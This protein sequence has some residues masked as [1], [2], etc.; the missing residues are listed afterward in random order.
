MERLEEEVQE[1][2]RAI[3]ATSCHFDKRPSQ[4]F[5]SFHRALLKF[6]FDAVDVRI[7]YETQ[8]IYI[9]NPKPLT[10]DPV[11]LFDMKEALA[12]K[13]SY[14][15]LEETLAGCLQNGHLQFSFYK[16]LIKEYGY[17]CSNGEDIMS[18]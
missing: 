16:K 9:S 6:S 12:D 5:C 13:L 1:Q 18:A 11:R 15:N 14:T 17:H 2:M 3:I 8:Q 10:T 4:H 7:D